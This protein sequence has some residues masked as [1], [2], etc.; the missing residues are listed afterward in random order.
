MPKKVIINEALNL[1]K[2][3]STPEVKNM[4]NACLDKKMKA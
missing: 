4:I 2:K 3:Y 1:A